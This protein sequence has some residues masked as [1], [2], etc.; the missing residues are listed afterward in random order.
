MLGG[1]N[2][3]KLR[4]SRG[5]RRH[6][7]S[8]NEGNLSLAASRTVLT[9]FGGN[10]PSF[11]SCFCHNYQKPFIIIYKR[12]KIPASRSL[13]SKNSLQIGRSCGIL[14]ALLRNIPARCF[15]GARGHP[16]RWGVFFAAFYLPF[17]GTRLAHLQQECQT[18][19]IVYPVSSAL[20]RKNSCQHN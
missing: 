6:T 10:L 8:L 9:G 19:L 3:R 17:Q 1:V 11:H 2:E 18:T 20:S 15:S 14:G 7:L 4:C 13:S 12:H 16:D 5:G